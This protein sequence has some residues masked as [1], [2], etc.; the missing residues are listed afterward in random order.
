MDNITLI[1]VGV[2]LI[3]FDFIFLSV[4]FT[5]IAP[6]GEYTQNGYTFI[7]TDNITEASSNLRNDTLGV[8]F[9]DGTIW[10]RGNVDYRT[11][12]TTCNHEMLHVVLDLPDFEIEWGTS[13]EHMII[14]TIEGSTHFP[15]CI[16][17]TRDVYNI[18]TDLIRELNEEENTGI[19]SAFYWK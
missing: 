9:P 8:A 18:S 2:G 6:I 1:Q 11:F 16:N 17:L 19:L 4:F 10:I 13:A 12:Y 7:V 15:E 14:N 5:G 3:I